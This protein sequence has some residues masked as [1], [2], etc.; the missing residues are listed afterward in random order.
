M[1]SSIL[2]DH[3]YIVTVVLTY[4]LS[5]NL[6]TKRGRFVVMDGLGKLSQQC[7]NLVTASQCHG[8]V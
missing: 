3:N 4:D 1:K 6:I 8:K 2:F 5:M 7:E